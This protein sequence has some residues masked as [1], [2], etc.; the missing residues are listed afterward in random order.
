MHA[1]ML[2]TMKPSPLQ[3]MKNNFRWNRGVKRIKEEGIVYIT[4]PDALG[5]MAETSTIL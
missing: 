5:C 3:G 4:M 1:H 2:T